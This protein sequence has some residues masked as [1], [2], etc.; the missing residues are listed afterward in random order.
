MRI[1]VTDTGCGIPKEKQSAVFQRFEKLDDY[2]SGAG[3][4]LS[5][6][7]LIAD[8]LGGTL[9]IDPTYENG[10]CFV[11][12]HPCEIPSST[13]SQGTTRTTLVFRYKNKN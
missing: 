12:T 11:F 3:L 4:G 10:A 8:H 1:S 5:I 7:T 2:K 6:C 9:S 13:Y